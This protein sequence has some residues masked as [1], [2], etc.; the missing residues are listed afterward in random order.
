MVIER[1][2]SQPA[3][4]GEGPCWHAEEQRLYWVDIEGKRLH[5]LD[6]ETGDAASWDFPERIGTVAPRKAGGL[7]LAFPDRLVIFHPQTGVQEP[8][9]IVD[10]NPK[11][12]LNDGKCDPQGR[13][14]VGSMDLEEKKSIG[15]LYRVDPDGTVTQWAD[16]IGVSNGLAWSPDERSMFYIDSPTRRVFVFDMDL[17]TG[18]VS[19]RRVFC[20]F[21][22]DEGFPDGMTSDA[23]GNLWVA[24]WAGARITRRDSLTGAV[25]STFPT[26]AYQT[27]AC[28]FGGPA[29]TDLYITSAQMNLT[30]E[31]A[32]EY[33]DSGHLLRL[34]PGLTGAATHA[35]GD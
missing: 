21:D 5:R 22:E 10:P 12:R 16:G 4:L 8:Y 26:R 17:A 15:G 28:C 1:L 6:P 35:F 33:P 20:E 19:D 7:L 30:Q 14:W 13:F 29:L 24:H 3:R 34:R 9:V 25:L 31:Q 23:E 11:T 2:T 27:S 32:A 18:V